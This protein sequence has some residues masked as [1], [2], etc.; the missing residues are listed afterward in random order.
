MTISPL[1]RAVEDFAAQLARWRTERGL[2]KR[3]L[4]AQMRFDPSYVSHVEGR[5]HR[6]TED[7]ARRAENVLDAGGA[8][9]DSY[10]AYEELR[11]SAPASAGRVPLARQETDGWTVPGIGLIVEREHAALGLKLE[12]IGQSRYHVLIRRQ[13]YNVGT[14]PIVRYPVRIHVDRYPNHPRRSA[15]THH[16]SPLVWSE[17][18]FSARRLGTS[19]AYAMEGAPGGG[20]DDEPMVWRSS[21]ESDARK[22]MWLH[23]S[24]GDRHFPLY[25]GQRA[26]IEYGYHVTTDK[27]GPWFQRSVHWP[28]REMFVELDFPTET[29]AVV[30]GT[31]SSL[32]AEGV[33]LSTPIRAAQDAERMTFTW[34]VRSPIMGA[35]YRFEWRLRD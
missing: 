16:G 6:P 7:F 23:F 2:S 5:R 29:Q 31:M 9:W 33:A 25:P 32:S 30:W 13:L 1:E 28:T 15:Q 12:G 18:G 24:N 26:T 27:W 21:H 11:Q 4:A 35:R 3:A 14:E 17:L 19:S 34:S 20:I 8:I 10:A 22:E